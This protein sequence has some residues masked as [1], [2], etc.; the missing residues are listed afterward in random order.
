MAFSAVKNMNASH[1]DSGAAAAWNLDGQACEFKKTNLGTIPANQVFF[2]T[3]SLGRVDVNVLVCDT[4]E[5]GQEQYDTAFFDFDKDLSNGVIAKM[6]AG[7]WAPFALTSLNVPP[8]P[9]FP[10]FARGTVGA[11]VKLTA[12]TANLSAFNLYSGDIF[13]NVGYPQAF[14]SE[15]D[16]SLGFWPAEPDFFNL[17]G[18]RIEEATYM[19]QLER[20]AIY[21]KDA[22][23]S[24]H[25]EI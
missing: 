8:D 17:E 23:L 15:I 13:H 4:I 6:K 19:E 10:D 16:K 18:G 24:G 1:F 12:F 7:E 20:L 9:T 14:V 5:N 3:F 22:M 2:Q 25:R 21:L 11:W